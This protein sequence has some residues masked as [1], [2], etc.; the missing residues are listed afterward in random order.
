MNS[1]EEE[2]RR[3]IVA[4]RHQCV[5]WIHLRARQLGHYTKE[6]HK[7]RRLNLAV[8]HLDLAVTLTSDADAY[9]RLGKAYSEFAQSE[10]KNE[11]WVVKAREAYRHCKEADLRGEYTSEIDKL[12]QPQKPDAKPDVV[13]QVNRKDVDSAT[14]SK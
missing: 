11:L 10:P 13:V 2:R 1:S 12:L 5:G 7:A 8:K 14:Q 9:Y 6:V 4:L 3:K